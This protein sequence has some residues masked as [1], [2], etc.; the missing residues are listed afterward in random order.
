MQKIIDC[1]KYSG[2]KFKTLPSL[3]ELVEGKISLSQFRDVSF[4]DLLRRRKLI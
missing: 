3:S 4:T 2:K 1:C